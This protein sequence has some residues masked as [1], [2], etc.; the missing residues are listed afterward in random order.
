MLLKWQ[1]TRDTVSSVRYELKPKKQFML[2]KWQLTR[3]TVSS[4][5]YELKPKKQFMLLKWQLTRYTVFSVRH[6]LKLKINLTT[7]TDRSS[8]IGSKPAE[9][10]QQLVRNGKKNI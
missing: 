1:L 10:S 4:V 8:I 2:L 9:Q 3:D 5:R 7:Y 6:E